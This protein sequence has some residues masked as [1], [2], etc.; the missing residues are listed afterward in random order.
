VS[1]AQMDEPEDFARA[2]A[3]GTAEALLVL[4]ILSLLQFLALFLSFRKEGRL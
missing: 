2:T 1:A 4:L 3:L